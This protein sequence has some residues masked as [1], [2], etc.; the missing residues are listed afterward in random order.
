MSS[1][2]KRTNGRFRTGV[3]LEPEVIQYLN[4]LAYRM[5]MNRSWVLNT[6]VHEYAKI[7]EQKSLMPLSSREA[8]I[9]I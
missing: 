2:Y 5:G 1:N 4:E 6:I 8:L 9:R 3:S 7:M